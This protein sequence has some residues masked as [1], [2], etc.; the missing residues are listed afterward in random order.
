MA[1]QGPSRSLLFTIRLWPE[2]VESGHV[3]WRGKVQ[4]VLS[5]EAFY[6]S[7]WD[8]LVVRLRQLV[9]EHQDDRQFEDGCGVE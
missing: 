6:F 7:N 3:Q 2:P 9:A 5:S 4:H 1:D 8:D